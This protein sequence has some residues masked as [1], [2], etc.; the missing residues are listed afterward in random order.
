MQN[1]T[2]YPII[3]T[4]VL[5]IFLFIT[6]CTKTATT[7]DDTPK[8]I[9]PVGNSEM[10]LKIAGADF[11][12]VKTPLTSG[13]IWTLKTE[14]SEEQYNAVLSGTTGT[15]KPKALNWN[16]AAVFCNKLCKHLK[17]SAQADTLGKTYAIFI[18]PF[19]TDTFTQSFSP[20]S[21]KTASYVAA[22][23]SLPA[24][25]FKTLRLSAT[26]RNPLK[27]RVALLVSKSIK[28][29]DTTTVR[30][31]LLS[32]PDSVALL[33]QGNTTLLELRKHIRF[34]TG[35]AKIDTLLLDTLIKTMNRSP[36]SQLTFNTY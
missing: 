8:P 35:A 29:Y 9:T 13:H 21:I 24:D 33:A 17:D 1:N 20:L 5:A 25:S 6:S 2:N 23:D 11:V 15:K 26:T 18:K 14:L 28:K 3:R 16:D 10:K 27:Q 22:F 34:V 4:L 7:S 31:A 32:S 12:F 30:N 19:Y 36:D